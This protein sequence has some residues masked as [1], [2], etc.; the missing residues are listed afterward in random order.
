MIFVRDLRRMAAFYGGTLGLESIDDSRTE[1]WAEFDA[2]RTRLVLHAIP[3]PIAETIELTLPVRAREDNPV[4]LMFEVDDLE[5]KM[6]WL[7]SEGVTIVQRPWGACDVID[8]E[9]NIFQIFSSTK[10]AIGV[11]YKG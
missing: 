6:I 8:P 10:K 11:D 1:S 9:G 3:S 2:G 5:A 7:E 4:K